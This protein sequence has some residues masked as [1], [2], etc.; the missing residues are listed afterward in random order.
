MEST[1]YVKVAVRD[2]R[3]G[4]YVVELDRPWLETPFLVQGF[5]IQSVE[6]LEVITDLCQYVYVDTGRSRPFHKPT[7]APAAA[8]RALTQERLRQTLN[9]PLQPYRDSV[10][11]KDELVSAR[12]VYGDY[13]TMVLRFY[14]DVRHN[15]KIDLQ[16]LQQPVNDIVDSV[17]RNPD[18]CLLLT[19]LKQKGDYTYNHAIGSSVWAAA[20]G[21]Q[22]GLPKKI[23]VS[24]ATGALLL[25]VGK[26]H[27]S[28][29]LLNKN[30][31]FTPQEIELAKTHVHRGMRML[32][33]SRG[34]DN[35]AFQMLMTHHERHNGKGYPRGL[36][37][38]AIPVYGRIA[39]IV[40]TY[41]ALI[42]DKPYRKG[43]APAEAIKVLYNVRDV[44]FQSEL[45]E[46]FIQAL[47]VYPAGSLV[48]LTSGEVAIVVTEHRN[49]RLRPQV[50][51][52][53]DA[54]KTPC[55][56]HRYLDLHQVTHDAAGN[57]LEIRKSLNPGDYG[58]V[59]EDILI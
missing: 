22:L 41:D 36:K 56:E 48:E 43:L 27:L 23:M 54:D 28:D 42:N 44:D 9:V 49:R 24:V 8:K 32:E 2:L 51:L 5:V 55:R 59:P 25:D 58:V 1:R 53:L 31:R 3:I 29:R 47:G 14:D 37:E 57:P 52:L 4:M 35:V 30:G 39:G 11:F 20:M 33:K 46:E 6:Q 50:L 26:L 45:V 17:I 34:V 12:K 15:N 19:R 7:R 18:A 38:K 40:D 16:E 10:N 13:E 21:R